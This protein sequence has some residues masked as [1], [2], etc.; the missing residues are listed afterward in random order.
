M[1]TIISLAFTLFLVI[2]SL[3]MAPALLSYISHYP[4]ARQKMILMREILF[5][6]VL[7]L[8]VA[9]IGQYFFDWL[10][11]TDAAMQ[12]AGG[13]ILFF[14]ALRMIFPQLKSKDE[15]LVKSEEPFIVPIATPM[16][17]GPA[18]FATVMIQTHTVSSNLLLLIAICIAFILSGIILI[19]VCSLQKFIGARGLN[20]LEKLMGLV[21]TLIAVQMLLKGIK[22]FVSQTI[23]PL[24]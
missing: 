11:I 1:N 7:T 14:I 9:L 2:N 24:G 16:L 4:R 5:A 13:I 15:G 10:Y 23:L 18:V 20:A 21:L 3:G 6:L 19:S 8:I 22:I 12:I 17:A